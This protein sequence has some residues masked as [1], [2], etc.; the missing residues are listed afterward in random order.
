MKLSF[1]RGLLVTTL[2]GSSFLFL[3]SVQAASACKGL[4]QT[5]C[6]AEQSCGW[7][8]AYSRKDGREVKAFCRT[9]SKPAATK[10]SSKTPVEKPVA[11]K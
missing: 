3:G 5:A 11:A 2:I 7:V 8:N 10:E 1:Q 9:K 6:Q 4:E